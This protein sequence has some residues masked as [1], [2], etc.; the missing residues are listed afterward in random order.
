MKKITIKAPKKKKT[1]LIIVLAIVLF[2][3]AV[4]GAGLFIA[5][6]TLNKMGRVDK[7]KELDTYVPRSQEDFEP[8]SDQDDTMNPDDAQW[9]EIKA[10]R[11]PDVKNILLIGQDRRPGET[12][13]TRADTMIVCSLNKK[14]GA[15]N[16]VSLMRDM[17]VPIPAY[18]DNRIN[19]AYVFGGMSLLDEVIRRNFGI[20]IDGNVEVDFNGFITAMSQVA[21][22]DIELKSYEVSYM[23]NG[24]GWNL[25]EG[26]NSLNAEQLLT[27]ARIRHVGN[28]DYER[29][30]RQ[31]RVVT[32]AF[33]KLK[34]MNPM[35]IYTIVNNALPSL[36]TDMSNGEIMSYVSYL[37]TDHPTIRGNYRLPADGSFSDQIIYGMMVL[38]PDL[39]KNARLIQT[40]LYGKTVN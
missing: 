25:H 32:A 15:I 22:L 30:E 7:N 17:Y 27:Y 36:T 14:T 5:N 16:L 37:I 29:T 18:T 26:L 2:I 31:R 20:Y 19:A 23:N 13:R 6:H 28:A 8:D 39:Q 11:D 9:A 21:P 38:V 40:Y 4:V 1:L 35:Q 33:S 24:T 12:G 3:G 34:S 10:M